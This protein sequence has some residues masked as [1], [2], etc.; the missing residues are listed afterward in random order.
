[1]LFVATLISAQEVRIG[2]DFQTRF[3]DKEFGSMSLVVPDLDIESGTDFAARL[4]PQAEVVWEGVNSLVVGVDILQNFGDASDRFV[5]EIKPIVYYQYKSSKVRAA[6]G[7]FTRDMI[8]D[9]GYSSAFFTPSYKFFH[10]RLQGVMGQYNSGR[11]YVEL[12]CDWESIY[13]VES[14]E[15]F[16]ILSSGRHYLKN[17]Y[18]GYNF[19]LFHFAGQEG[20]EVEN[21]VDYALLNPR[22]GVQFGG[23][24]DFDIFA[25]ALLSA[26]RDGSFGDEWV[27]PAMGEV[28]FSVARWGFT[29][30]NSIYF[31]DNLSPFF[32][33]H[34][35]PSGAEM[36]Y[37]RE[38]YPGE[39]FFRTENG[40][41]NRFEAKYSKD[42]FNDT[43]R[44]AA[45]ILGHYDGA[46]F[47]TQYMLEVGVRLSGTVYNSKNHKK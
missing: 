26:Q 13:S 3:D 19:T 12:I 8:H 39:S 10:N 37:G 43:V 33:G 22:V 14:R 4:L 20:A 38:L 46:D 35:L 23:N 30:S 45:N 25:T 1:M 2:V 32:F 16:R 18:Y 28:G 31:G 44:V 41:Y 29:L 27:L 15:K 24:F 5:S 6:A 36:V 11:S 7:I 47:G 9:D 42:F 17:F 40:V 21:V 34:T